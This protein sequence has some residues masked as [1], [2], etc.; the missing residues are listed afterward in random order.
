METLDHNE[1]NSNNQIPE[2]AVRNLQQSS[3]WIIIVSA[4]GMFSGLYFLYIATA[5][6]GNRYASSQGTI[7]MIMSLVFIT[8]HVLGLVYGIALSKLKIYNANDFDAASSKQMT[9]WVFCGIVYII[10]FLLMLMTLSSG[11]MR[12]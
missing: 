3:V 5:A 10:W 1:T 7:L 11:G 2:R 12:F 9:Y 6:M 4:V 8:M